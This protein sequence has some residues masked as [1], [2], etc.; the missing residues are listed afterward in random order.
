MVKEGQQKV[1]KLGT[2]QKQTLGFF[3]IDL[4]LETH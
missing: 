3:A 4:F 1:W 2:L